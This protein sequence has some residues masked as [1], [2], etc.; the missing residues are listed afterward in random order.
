MIV[1]IEGITNEDDALLSV[2]LGADMVGFVFAPSPR[3]VAPQ[4]AADI[5]KRLPTDEVIAVGVFRDEHPKRVVE[6]ALRAGMRGV[7]LHGEET[8]DQT[9][10]IRERI[11]FVIKAFAAGDGRVARAADYGADVVLLDAPSPGSGRVFDWA[12][13]AEVPSGRRF[14]L[15]G[16]LTPDNVAGAIVRTRCWGVDVASGVERS[17]GVKDPVKLRSFIAAAKAA[18]PEPAEDAADPDDGPYDWEAEG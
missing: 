1:K 9:R 15:A 18:A 2:A 14:M 10:W 6:V 3:Q 13:A 5:A 16:G 7:Q 8:P 17:P 4:V 11:P 12:L